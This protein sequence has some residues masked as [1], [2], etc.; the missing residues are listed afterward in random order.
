MMKY[1]YYHS[2]IIH[3]GRRWLI[4]RGNSE[5]RTEVERRDGEEDERRDGEEDERRDGE[6][7]ERRDG[8]GI[9]GG[10]KKENKRIGKKQNKKRNW[11]GITK[12]S[13]RTNGTI[14]KD[15]RKEWEL[16][17]I[18]KEKRTRRNAKN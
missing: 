14:K 4:W 1:N 5:E 11:R 17:R 2:Y 12:E 10:I 15:G 3:H 13:E 16:G 6:E 8:E 7:D 18:K 9:N